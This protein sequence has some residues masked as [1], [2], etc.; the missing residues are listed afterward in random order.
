MVDMSHAGECPFEDAGAPVHSVTSVQPFEFDIK[1][2]SSAVIEPKNAN[3]EVFLSLRVI[4]SI[5]VFCHLNT[6]TSGFNCMLQYF[7]SHY[8]FTFCIPKGSG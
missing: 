1:Y 3:I 7:S 8:C 5:N 2:A 4:G 6:A